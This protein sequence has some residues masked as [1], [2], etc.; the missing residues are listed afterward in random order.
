[1]KN[2]K[3]FLLFLILLACNKA[4][5]QLNV[6][7][8][9]NLLLIQSKANFK[10][11]DSAGS[12]FFKDSLW[13]FGGFTPQRSNE[14]INSNDG[15]IWN[16][17]PVPTFTP[18]NLMG[19]VVFENKIFLMGGYDPDDTTSN[20]ALNDVYTSTDG[21]KWTKLTQNAEW[22]ARFAFG[23]TVLNGKIYIFGG[24]DEN[25]NHLNDIWE[26]KDGIHWNKIVS[27]A[28]WEPRGM[29][30]TVVYKQSLYLISGGIYNENYVYNIQKNYS[31]I[32]KTKDFHNWELVIN[33]IPFLPRRFHNAFSI[34]NEIFIGAGFGLTKDLFND[35]INGI[36]SQNL[37]NS[38]ALKYNLS[39]GLLFCNLN[40]I[41]KSDNG[42]NWEKVNTSV[43]FPR[44]H[45]SSVIVKSNQAYWI[46]GWGIEMYNDVW[47]F[48]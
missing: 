25:Y 5:N 33:N 30:A 12:L 40:D 45:A 37:S 6:I 10:P 29:F 4:D 48:N 34:N 39:S 8:S 46:G 44:R 20:K 36:S 3:F 31:D 15:I 18:R 42:I 41:W 16:K 21:R 14:I 17:L 23:C 7:N 13:L 24:I 47:R 1:M 19:V 22:S 26:S 11:R 28:P 32:W 38:D 43:T 9:H 2:L 27:H 35:S